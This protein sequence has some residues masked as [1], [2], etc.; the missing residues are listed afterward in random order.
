M[1]FIYILLFL[2]IIIIIIIICNN[3]NSKCNYIKDDTISSSYDLFSDLEE[4]LYSSDIYYWAFSCINKKKYINTIELNIRD[5]EDPVKFQIGVFSRDTPGTDLSIPFTTI[6]I[7]DKLFDIT[8]NG[9]QSFSF[10]TICLPILLDTT[11][12]YLG[13]KIITTD[14][15]TSKLNL[16]VKNLKNTN[17]YNYD[18]ISLVRVNSKSTLLIPD[19]QQKGKIVKSEFIAYLQ[20]YHKS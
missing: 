5:L 8:V 17:S 9:F 1:N 16:A 12:Y 4:E 7:I 13:F 20:C 2:L 19:E 11:C 10:D 6:K 15:Q 14:T 3:I 18:N